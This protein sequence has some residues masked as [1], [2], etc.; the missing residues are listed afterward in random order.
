MM[1][2][3]KPILWGVN[4]KVVLLIA[5]EERDLETYKEVIEIYSRV[6]S[7]SYIE[8]LGQAQTLEEFKNLYLLLQLLI[9]LTK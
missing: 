2:L 8:Q 9:H 4:F 7:A 6:D 5:I 3:D 1:T